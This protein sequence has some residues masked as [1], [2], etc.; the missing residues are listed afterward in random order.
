MV[1]SQLPVWIG[2]SLI[3]VLLTFVLSSVGSALGNMAQ[4]GTVLPGADAKL[5]AEGWLIS[6]GISLIV[7]SITYATLAGMYWMGLKQARGETISVGD[8]FYPFRFIIPIFVASLLQNIL[9]MLGL[10]ACIIPFFF[11][12]GALCFT[13]LL[14]IDRRVGPLEAIRLGFSTLKGHA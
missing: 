5:T 1:K 9:M 7:N 4:F 14:V 8:I 3:Y 11:V 13:Q 10:L 2:A 12:F 6:S